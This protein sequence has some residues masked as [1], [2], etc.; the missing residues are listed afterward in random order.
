MRKISVVLKIFYLLLP[1]NAAATGHQF[2]V[3]Y[4][5]TEG[6]TGQHI[7]S[8]SQDAQGRMW[9]GTGN[10]VFYYEGGRFHALD[11]YEYMQSCTKMTFA[12][13]CDSGRRVWIASS[14][15]AGYYDTV[16]G[17]FIPVDGFNT[18]PA[19]D[20][21][22]DPEGNVWIT[23]RSG[24]WKYDPGSRSVTGVATVLDYHPESSC[25]SSDGSNLYILSNEGT[26]VRHEMESGH[27]IEI[28]APHGRARARAIA[29][30][31]DGGVDIA[32]DNGR[33][34]RL[35]IESR[36]PT[37]ILNIS[38]SAGNST[39]IAMLEKDGLL[40]IGTSSGMLVHNLSTRAL[41]NQTGSDEEQ[42]RL[43]GLVV[44]EI[45]A[46][47]DGNIWVGTAN[48]GLHVWM[49]YGG[50]FKRY[51]ADGDDSSLA[52]TSIRAICADRAGNIWTGSE[53]GQLSRFNPSSEE[54]EDFSERSGIRYGTVITSIKE[55]GGM[56]W[57]ATYGDGL[58]EFDPAAGRTIR[59]SYGETDRF[60]ALT[61]DHNGVIRVGTDIGIFSV[62]R[63][64]GALMRENPA[65]GFPVHSLTEDSYGRIWMGTYG[66]GVCYW[67]PG[68]AD[69][70]LI[71]YSIKGGN[72]L[73]SNYI[74]Y[75]FNDSED[76]LWVCS[77]GSGLARIS[78]S[79]DGSILGTSHLDTQSGLPSNDV[80]AVFEAPDGHIWVLTT[81]GMAEINRETMRVLNVY[82]Q[83]DDVIGKFFNPGSCLM[84]NGS[85]A[86]VGSYRGLLSFNPTMMDELF[87]MKPVHINGL[88]TGSND[89]PGS[90]KGG[91]TASVPSD[92]LKVRWK[93]ASML[94]V[95]FS[96][97]DYANPNLKQYDCELKRYGFTSSITTGD[98]SASYVG[99]RPG[100]YTFTVSALG[101][102]AG[103]TA[104][105]IR[106][107]IVP[108][109]YRSVLARIIYVLLALGG[110]AWWVKRK[111]AE[112]ERVVKFKEAQTKMQN[113][114][115]QMG[116]LTNVTHEI[117][118][119]V[120]MMTIL[121]DR[122]FKKKDVEQDE[123]LLSMK[124]NMNK[125]LELCDQ[126]LDYRKLENEQIR[127][128]PDD[129][130][131]NGLVQAAVES[132]RPAAE[133][134]GM[135][136]VVS[137]PDHPVLARCDRNAV[138]SIL[139]N[140]LSNAVKYGSSRISLEL[141]SSE[142]EAVISVES[143]GNIIPKD[144][145]ELIFNAFYQSDPGRSAGTGIGLTYARALANMQNGSLF[146]DTEKKDANRF[147]FTLPLSIQG[148]V[149]QEPLHFQ[150]A[151]DEGEE[152]KESEG[153][154]LVLVV[155]D[156]DSLRKVIS[157][158]LSDDYL[159]LTASDGAEALDIIKKENVDLVVSDIMM[160][161]MD[162]CSLCNAIKDDLHTSHIMVI[163]LTAAIGVDNHIRSL[164]AGADG[165]IEKPFRV[166]LLKENIRNLFRNRE[167]RNEQFA[168]SPLSHFRCAS[169]SSVEQDFMETLNN[170]IF[171]HISDTDMSADRLA[172][173][174][175][176]TRKTLASK[177]SAN[178]GL[179][180]NEYVRTCRLKKA[181]ELLSK[182]KYRINEVG[183]LVGY[184]TP[185]Y[186]TKHFTAQFG[187]KPSDFL[188]SL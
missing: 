74:N 106:F 31:E 11:D 156:N 163:L 76:D 137:M 87:E 174:M 61:T 66:Q 26:V 85:Q 83:S 107:A 171:E 119:P 93:D 157:E 30:S 18:I 102:E 112:H 77:E 140:L 28:F 46:D 2:L 21:D 17:K 180:V 4:S 89:D 183:Y 88:D 15:G 42:F 1:L 68:T 96:T 150:A 139:G 99:L 170:Y 39:V 153:K 111:K 136:F 23:S 98:N 143:D 94:T 178:T 44:R 116:F 184:S 122:I 78:F 43:S 80:N 20:L 48:G 128:H 176:T 13:C 84:A 67:T 101:D 161:V 7:R 148:E 129:E 8:C 64:S 40:W 47:A 62:D 182:N 103:N 120:T 16:L 32:L 165:Y 158:E 37:R 127:L 79:T 185:S 57:I 51:V 73:S 54:F 168:S 92:N 45:F 27:N 105:S 24:I 109:W 134:R 22:T 25:F 131:L 144:E 121:M 19:R 118:T 160:P 97:Y 70:V 114:H 162:G 71:P 133:A 56:L 110:L 124:S 141:T 75:L 65:I 60:F 151:D 49:G 169:F 55:V 146:L 145:S 154:P 10:G 155:E 5:S 82:M 108:P 95:S 132:F 41:D 177:I 149:L 172:D 173:A 117:R 166:E 142:K 36:R 38:E 147:V 69:L 52:G 35:D 188:K 126:M 135:G 3:K 29:A 104:D 181:A 175:G 63:A 115:E 72:P 187:M 167:I 90:F 59:R 86:Y 9:I 12:V 125:L 186:F 34:I 179:T 164:K 6:L 113:L 138:E 100:H 33:I 58:F 53:E 81:N 14:N 123:D 50:N 152:R 91:G 130:A 159:T